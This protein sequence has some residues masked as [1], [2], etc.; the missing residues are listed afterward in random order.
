MTL[1]DLKMAAMACALANKDSKEGMTAPDNEEGGQQEGVVDQ[2]S[3]KEKTNQ[4]SDE[5]ISNQESEEGDSN[6][7]MSES[8]AD[9]D[10]ENKTLATF[11]AVKDQEGE[12]LW[13]DDSSDDETWSVYHDGSEP[14]TG[15]EDICLSAW[16]GDSY[17]IKDTLL[18]TKMMMA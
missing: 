8:D 16:S 9:S 4:D 3:E 18:Q 14:L 7:A 10:S 2:D 17:G 11:V 15:D 12:D 1:K 13:W 5:G 6:E